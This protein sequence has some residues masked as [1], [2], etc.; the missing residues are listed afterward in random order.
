MCV[1]L[2]VLCECVE[3]W[4]RWRPFVCVVGVVS[5]G[6][7]LPPSLITRRS[8]PVP[9]RPPCPFPTTTST[10]FLPPLQAHNNPCH[11]TK[12][13][14][15][16]RHARAATSALST[17]RSCTDTVISCETSSTRL[18][19][20][21]RRSATG[22]STTLKKQVCGYVLLCVCVYSKRICHWS[23][24]DAE[25]AVRVLVCTC[26]RACVRACEY[27]LAESA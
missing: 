14:H 8:C 4:R 18:S 27:V 1:C 10:T 22:V 20:Q 16:Q 3:V 21:T 26:V 15:T 6:M 7:L 13:A 19:S 24:H 9:P 25:K 17:C 23:Q 11:A 12:H 5:E 2:S